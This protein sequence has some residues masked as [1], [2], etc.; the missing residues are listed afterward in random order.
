MF[1]VFP[2]SPG[3]SPTHIEEKEVTARI[4]FPETQTEGVS[5]ATGQVVEG[6]EGGGDTREG[7]EGS[8][9]QPP[10]RLTS[11]PPPVLTKPKPKKN[12]VMF[13]EEV[14]DIPS[15]EP[16]I[17]QELASS[18]DEDIPSTV[19]ELK[20]M[21]FGQKQTQKYTKEGPMSLRYGAIVDT[22]DYDPD[23]HAML[24]PKQHDT[25]GATQ[26]HEGS[27]SL[28]NP[29][30]SSPS[31]GLRR[32]QFAPL[33]P[34][35]GE[36]GR[37][38]SSLSPQDEGVGPAPQKIPDMGQENNEYDTP[39]DHKPFSKYSVVGHRKRMMAAS[40]AR[41]QQDRVEFEVMSHTTAVPGSTERRNVHSLERRKVRVEGSASPQGVVTS[42]T[43]QQQKHASPPHHEVWGG[44]L[45]RERRHVSPPQ[46]TQP[47][48]GDPDLLTSISSTL[49]SRSKYGSDSFLS[50][51]KQSLSQGDSP[52]NNPPGEQMQ[53]GGQVRRSAKADLEMIRTEH[54]QE[55]LQRHSLV[56][57]LSGMN[58]S[59]S[60]SAKKLSRSH[61]A[62]DGGRAR[63]GGGGGGRIHT[64]SGFAAQKNS[65]MTQSVDGLQSDP[66]T[67]VM[68][69]QYTNSHTFRSLV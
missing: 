65:R 43:Q 31:G 44:S 30:A 68:Y 23:L 53:R 20:M 29:E 47:P 51:G 17:D 1:D 10:T 58:G 28:Q 25:A 7:G 27:L 60:H 59:M 56:S 69:D 14:E 55:A 49:Q 62:M 3:C 15:Y 39:W 36:E 41:Q 67:S 42:P 12:R 26:E 21:L 50:M 16:R 32:W 8:K 38:S 46:P 5:A 18:G 66:S 2:F 9:P 13:K 11:A 40:Q 24:S 35:G 48:A 61:Q 45:E 54:R 52:I 19:A 37:K 34:P 64:R 33:S 6:E 63:G 4:F 57:P 22:E